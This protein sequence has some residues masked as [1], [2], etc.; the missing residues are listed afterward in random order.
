MLQKVFC[1]AVTI[2]VVC[3]DCCTESDGEYDE[4]QAK[5]NNTM[6]KECH[7]KHYGVYC[8]NENVKTVIGEF[9]KDANN[10]VRS[11]PFC[12]YT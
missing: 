6:D 9:V 1:L 11:I 5:C 10:A 12:I 3:S 4:S 8:C 7:L 2:T